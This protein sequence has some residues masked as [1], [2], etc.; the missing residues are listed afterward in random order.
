MP[1]D[2]KCTEGPPAAFPFDF[3]FEWIEF[4]NVS[5][6]HVP[7]FN[8]WEPLFELSVRPRGSSG[9]VSCGF[10]IIISVFVELGGFCNSAG[11]DGGTSNVP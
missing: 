10:L 8:V 5:S 6:P 9:Y 7:V 3:S 2:K 4:N 1:P 11:V